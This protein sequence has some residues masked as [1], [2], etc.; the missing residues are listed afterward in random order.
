MNSVQHSFTTLTYPVD[1]RPS[2]Y[3]LRVSSVR[4]IPTLDLASNAADA[5][6]IETSIVAGLLIFDAE[7][8]RLR[9]QASQQQCGLHFQR[10]N[11]EQ[12]IRRKSADRMNKR[13]VSGGSNQIALDKHPPTASYL[14]TN[15]VTYIP[16]LF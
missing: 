2:D 16:R 14:R 6:A 15:T 8:R 10:W 4:G 11:I 3:S 12:F 5:S 13:R 9:T 7:A 1:T